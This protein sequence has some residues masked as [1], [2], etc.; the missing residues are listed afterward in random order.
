MRTQILRG[1]NTDEFYHAEG[2]VKPGQSYADTGTLA[3]SQMLANV[4]PE[5]CKVV[6]KFGRIHHFVN[7]NSFKHRKLIRRD[8]YKESQ[9][10]RNEY[11]MILKDIAKK[12]GSSASTRMFNTDCDSLPAKTGGDHA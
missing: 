3:K 11:G 1:G 10:A 4:Y 12:S 8:E 9:A 7:Y 2:E 6:R 5:Y